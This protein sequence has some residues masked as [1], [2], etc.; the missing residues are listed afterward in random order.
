MSAATLRS[1]NLFTEQ[2]NRRQQCGDIHAGAKTRLL[3]EQ[4]NILSGDVA[5]RTWCKW[6]AAQP[7][8]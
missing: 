8:G 5:F 3:T 7:A 2:F 1:A 4:N 6:T